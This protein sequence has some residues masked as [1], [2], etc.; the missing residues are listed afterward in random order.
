MRLK[1]GTGI[2][3]SKGHQPSLLGEVM[4]TGHIVWYSVGYS[5]TLLRFTV[6]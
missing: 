4:K 6:K 5:K 2:R 3:Q 1:A